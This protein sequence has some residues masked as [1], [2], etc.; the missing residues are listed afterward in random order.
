MNGSQ[1]KAIFDPVVEEVVSLMRGQICATN[2]KVKAVLMVGGF[3]QNAYLRETIRASIDPSIEV[4]QPPNG[5]TAVVRGALMKGLS[6]LEPGTERVK[7]ASR[8]A[9]KHYGTEIISR[10]D[11]SKHA[12]ATSWWDDYDGEAKVFDMAWFITKGTPVTENVPY[13]KRYH[14]VWK[15]ADKPRQTVA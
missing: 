10:Y 4:M 8:V 5:W 12:K 9:R 15:V 6:Q 11:S 1:V 3:G 13:V 7:V 2:K 14:K